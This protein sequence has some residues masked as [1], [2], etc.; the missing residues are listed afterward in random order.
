[1]PMKFRV[2][3][4]YGVLEEI[5]DGRVHHGID[6]AM[7]RGTE[8]HSIAEGTIDRVIHN[9]LIGNGVVVRTDSGDQHI[10]GHL[11]KI[12]VKPGEH[13]DVG[14]LIGLSG[15]TG[16]STGPHLHFS[17][18]HDGQYADPSH[19]ISSLQH[20][21]GD[22]AGPS[23]LA[24]KGP[25]SWVAG[26]AA[27]HIQEHVVSGVRDHIIHF[28]GEVAGAVVDLSY[29]F[30]LIGCAALIVLGAIGLRNGY[31]WSGLLFGSYTLVRLIFGGMSR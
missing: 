29:G 18:S 19:L 22:I 30:G 17:L 9:D 25:A 4:P 7:P 10:Y 26:K 8:L 21:S 27:E 11:D 1:M 2:S 15:N 12:S 3:S 28:L 20:Y 31:R 13:V 16:H 24:V 14:E 6:L 5:R 23:F